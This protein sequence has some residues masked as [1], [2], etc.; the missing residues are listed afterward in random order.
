MRFNIAKEAWEHIK[1]KYHGTTRMVFVMRQTLRQKFELLQM[2]E[3]K[4]IQ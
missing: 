3:E 4:A 1:N 2:K